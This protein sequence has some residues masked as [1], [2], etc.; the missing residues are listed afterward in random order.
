[1][2]DMRHESF[3]LRGWCSRS[4]SFIPQHPRPPISEALP[5]VAF[6]GETREQGT[7]F[8]FNLGIFHHIF[9]NAVQARAG[10]VP[11]EPELVA[12]GRFADEGDFRHVGTRATIGATRG[13]ND[14]FFTAKAEVSAELLNS[15][16]QA[17]QH[18]LGLGQR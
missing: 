5:G 4:G 7:Q 6:R 18:A 3:L 16:D 9:P 17:R 14:D 10:F 13:T 8:Y 1:M 15:I 12:A 2:S 11:A